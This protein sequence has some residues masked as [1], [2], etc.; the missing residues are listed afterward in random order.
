MIIQYESIKLNVEHLSEFEPSKKT[1]LFLHGFTGS[2][3]DWKDIVSKIDK[4]FNKT[5]LDLIGHGK[6][7]SPVSV[8]YYTSE[9]NIAQIEYVTNHLRLKEVILCGYSMGGRVALSYAIAKK[10]M[11]KG[12]ILESAS[13]GMKNEKEREARR[14]SDEELAAYIENNSLEDFAAMWLDQELFG[15]LRRFS[16][17][18]LKDIKEEKAKNS[19]IGLANSLRGFGTGVMPYSGSELVK[20]KIPTLLITGGLDDK[21]TQINQNLKKTIPSAKHKIIS[22]S[23]H[24][25]HLEEPKKFIDA[26]NGFLSGLK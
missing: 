9:S 21:F 14:K 22:T 10:E 5:A 23:G 20:L 24:I 7:S 1:I 26:V 19:K 16:N 17:N 3:I 8:N 25:T 15:T 4:R 12:L 18:R 11:V 2:S 13:A 6:S